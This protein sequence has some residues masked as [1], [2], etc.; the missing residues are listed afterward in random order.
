MLIKECDIC[1]NDFDSSVAVHNFKCIHVFCYECHQDLKNNGHDNCPTCRADR[2]YDE[3]EQAEPKIAS[4]VQCYI[5]MDKYNDDSLICDFNCN[6][7][8][9][10]ECNQ[11]MKN[12]NSNKCPFCRS[13]RKETTKLDNNNELFVDYVYLDSNE[14]R[15]FSN[16]GHEYLID[17]LDH[18]DRPNSQDTSFLL[19]FN[20]PCREPL[21][22]NE[23]KRTPVDGINMYIFNLRP[24]DNR[25]TGTCNFSSLENLAISN[26][27]TNKTGHKSRNSYVRK[28]N[29]NMGKGKFIGR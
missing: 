7:K 8:I 20:H 10:N 21:W 26:K 13:Q 3:Y 9:C 19:N 22:A 14:R 16:V 25:P 28:S 4:L 5:C 17:Q 15:R 1:M 18:H 12:N 27:K 23:G 24:E 2:L 6:H 29:E 11:N